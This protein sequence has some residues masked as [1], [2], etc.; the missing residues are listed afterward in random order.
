MFRLT[1]FSLILRNTGWLVAGQ[2]AAKS[3]GLV[4]LL[5]LA[6]RL[7]LADFGWYTAALAYMA[8]VIP[9][10]EFGLDRVILRDG[11][12]EP[13]KLGVL[14]GNVLVGRS[15]LAAITAISLSV[16][17]RWLDYPAVMDRL[18]LLVAIGL[19]PR[20]VALTLEAGFQAQERMWVSALS[21][22]VTSVLA[23]LV[24]LPLF[25]RGYGINGIMTGI[26]AAQ[27]G[28]ALVVLSL[29]YRQGWLKYLS[30]VSWPTIRGLVGQ[31]WPFAVLGGLSLIT[32]R[33]DTVLLSKL[34]SAQN[35]G[36]Y[37]AAYKLVEV[38][39]LVPAMLSIALFPQFA[40]LML[41]SRQRLAGIYLRVVTVSG[42]LA[43]AGALIVT[44]TAGSMVKIL[45]GQSYLPAVPAMIILSWALVLI[46]INAPPAPL[47]QSSEYLVNYLP[48][49]IGL[50]LIN[51]CLNI[52]WIPKMGIQ[53]AAWATLG[54]EAVAIVIN[55][56]FVWRILRAKPVV[57]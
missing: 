39:V 52:W 2:I 34:V 22:L 21:L 48:V 56:L 24:G 4:Y 45:F 38:G 40:R 44:M 51:I 36:L 26:V 10:V 53:G 19:L 43:A 14:I 5:Y 9:V 42:L 8:M 16:L 25:W 1:K 32:F 23:P 55:N 49:A 12:R 57:V 46:F 28:S 20:M 41:P 31:A 47:I 29:S 18:L 37:N 15:L 35:L 54:T 6:R 7:S 27:A 11:S 13:G 17:V 33:V 50:L 30:Q 3:I